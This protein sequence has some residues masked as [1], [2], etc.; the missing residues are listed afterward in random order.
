MIEVV[1]RWEAWRQ[2]CFVDVV[3]ML[4]SAIL[5]CLWLP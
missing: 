5:Q 1:F 3:Y 4:S 2:R